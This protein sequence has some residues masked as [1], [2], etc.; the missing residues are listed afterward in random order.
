MESVLA[1]GDAFGGGGADPAERILIEFV[2]ANPTGPLVAASGRH[3]A[4]GDA[5]AR[6]LGHHGHTVSR[7][8]YFNDAGNQIRL[9]G[10]SVRARA[11]GEEVPEGGY[12]GEYVAELGDQIPGAAELP[13]DE[14]AARAVEILLGR[15]KATLER[16]GVHYDSFFSERTLHSGSPSMVERA[17][18]QLEQSGHVYRSEGALWLR[19]TEFGDDK[20]RVVVRSNGEPTYLA[21]DIAYLQEKRE[22]GLRSPADAGRSR[23]PRV[24]ADAEG[25][26]GGARRRPRHGGVADHP[27]RSP[28][29]R[30]RGIRDVKAP[31]RLRD[32]R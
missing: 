8:Y 29:P 26:D 30:G 24:R 12:Q 19:T 1:A 10:E 27:V 22:R 9:L 6:I 28:R 2:S 21:A 7:E 3:A 20:D 17:L 23:P 31:R 25:R 4:Y 14:L 11:R 16:Y 5:L 32:A 13:V 18:A 15:I